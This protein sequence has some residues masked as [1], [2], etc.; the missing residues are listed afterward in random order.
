MAFVAQGN[1]NGFF[2]TVSTIDKNSDSATLTYELQSADYATALAD[3]LII[4]ARL[5]AVSQVEV[6]GYSVSTRYVENAIAQP[7]SGE[8]QIKARVVVRLADGQGYASFDIPAPKE[9]IFMDTVGKANNIVDVTDTDLLNYA[10]LF[11]AGGKAYISD[12]ETIDVMTEGRKVSTR[13]GLRSR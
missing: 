4:I 8:S 10:A 13:T 7:T 3:S 9:E 12:G 1:G 6:V 5:V 11:Q 2:L